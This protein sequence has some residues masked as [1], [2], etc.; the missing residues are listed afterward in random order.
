MSVLRREVKALM[1]G[2]APVRR[3]RARHRVSPPA[4]LPCFSAARGRSLCAVGTPRLTTAPPPEGLLGWVSGS[5]SLPRAP[6][7]TP[8]GAPGFALGSE[9]DPE[10]HPRTASGG[11]AV[12]SRGVPT[13]HRERPFAAEKQGSAGGGDIPW[14]VPPGIPAKTSFEFPPQYPT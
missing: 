1:S 10:T 3:P 12:V 13:V 8:A 7:G 4:A 5:F 2:L 14:G 6:P 9:N 11:G